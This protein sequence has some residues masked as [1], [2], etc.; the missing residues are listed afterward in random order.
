MSFQLPPL[1]KRVFAWRYFFFI[2]RRPH[3]F[4]NGYFII[5]FVEALRNGWVLHIINPVFV[6]LTLL[7]LFLYSMLVLFSWV[8]PL[9]VC[10]F[11]L[12]LEYNFPSTSEVE[13]LLDLL[14]ITLPKLEL[15]N[16][17]CHSFFQ[18]SELHWSADFFLYDLFLFLSFFRS[19]SKKLLQSSFNLCHQG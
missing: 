2:S 15:V 14:H 16:P 3:S 10:M 18:T 4:P 13:I 11:P 6:I 5:P 12:N 9:I 19:L 17:I 7:C 1:I 8:K